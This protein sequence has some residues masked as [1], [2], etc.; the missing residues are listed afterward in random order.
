M[1]IAV[2]VGQFATMTHLSVK[3]LRHY[4][5][6]GLLEPVH[7]DSATG[8]RYYSL[9]Q[10]PTAQLIRRLRD[11][12]M[13]VADVRDVLVAQNPSDRESL[14][15]AHIDHL[16]AELA[17]TKAAVNSLRALLN[18]AASSQPVRRRAEPTTPAVA[19]TDTVDPVDIENWWSDALHDVREAVRTGR[20]DQTGPAGGIYDESLFQHEPG[21]ATVFIPVTTPRQLGRVNPIVVPAAEVVVTTHHGSAA[22]IDL[23]YAEL[24]SYIASHALA[25]GPRIREYYHCDHTHTPDTTQ[26]R[27]EVV[28]PITDVLPHQTTGA[29]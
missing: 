27:T 8:Y 16:E 14:I 4:H 29:P 7:V 18:N 10:L 17:Q 13:P 23:A 12:R 28:W 19:I 2:S 9:D 25:V 22:D 3:T 26:W 24:G 6:V 21:Q 15:A 1:S 11:L 20:L 5:H